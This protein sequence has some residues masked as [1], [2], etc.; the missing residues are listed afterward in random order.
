MR[1]DGKKVT[2][3]DGATQ[4]KNKSSEDKTVYGFDVNGKISSENQN[5][6]GINA[7]AYIMLKSLVKFVILSQKTTI[8]QTAKLTTIHIKIDTLNKQCMLE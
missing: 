2:S 7:I 6:N 4:W 3:A 1:E 5:I 8:S